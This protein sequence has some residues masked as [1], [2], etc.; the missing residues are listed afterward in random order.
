MRGHT[1]RLSVAVIVAGWVFLPAG[2]LAQQSLSHARVV[3]LSYVSGTVG[4][5]RP[6][7]AE[8][9]NA[10][11]NT[12]IQEGFELS[13]SATSYAEVEF[14]NG[15]SARLGELSQVCFNQL[16]LDAEG[17]KLNRLTFEQGYATFHF[18]PEHQD[19]YSVVVAD[20]TLTPS[21]KSEFRTDLKQGRVR[22]EVFNGTVDVTGR[23]GSTKL[24]KDKVL[25]FN[26][27]ATEL[28]F[29]IQQ[30]ITKDSWDKW[31]EARDNQV[32]L[33]MRDQAVPARGMLYG[34]GDLGAYGEWAM[35]PGFGYGWAPYAPMGWSPFSMGM[36]DNYPGFGLTWISSEPW[37]WLPY[38]YG[39]WNFDSDFGWFWMPGSFA[40]W[41]PALVTWYSGPGWLGWR[42]RGVGGRTGINAVTTVP[43]SVVRTG[44]MITL[45]NASHER[46]AAGS[47][48]TG[49]PPFQ[50]GARAT[51][52]G[53]PSGSGASSSLQVASPPSRAH[54]TPAPAAILMG[55]DAAAEKALLQ[56][57]PSGLGRA[58][59]FSH[60]QPLRAREGA[61]LGGRYAMGGTVGEF[62]G[63]AIS[64][65][66]GNPGMR[67][68]DGA[69]GSAPSRMSR[70]SGPVVLGHSQSAAPSSGGG[71]A[72]HAGG[73][74]GS[75]SISAS[76]SVSASSS[77]SSSSHSSSS[78]GGHH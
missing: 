20:A 68:G 66:G 64:R 30:G 37:G 23:S 50:S 49:P 1:V 44:Q 65:G 57:H 54:D 48:L 35:I 2:V 76:P 43:G 63:D 24:S 62:R 3:R 74:G 38:H 42:P 29:N 53:I 8:W 70:G 55:G 14:E 45:L 52:S 67:G 71:G 58:F 27:G 47:V 19:A 15:S 13:T 39:M 78:S 7:S 12:P 56:N 32:Q 77:V 18:M 51:L 59:G 40:Y 75:S 33:S 10:V 5:K 22:V 25:E 17:N 4:V 61:T 16:A 26:S 34:W 9:T 6:G 60:A 73:G 69:V 36:W 21:G 41:S 28:A 72:V 46:A 11:V 31:A